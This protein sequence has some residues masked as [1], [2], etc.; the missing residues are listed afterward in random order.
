MD[1]RLILS[2]YVISFRDGEH[3]Y[4]TEEYVKYVIPTTTATTAAA[5]TAATE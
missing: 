1:R 2:V 5:T 4:T 3:C